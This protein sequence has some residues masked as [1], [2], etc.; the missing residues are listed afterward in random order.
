MTQET[1]VLYP[2]PGIDH[3]ISMVEL[4]KLLQKQHPYSITILLTTGLLD[5]HS[6]D[7]YIRHISASHPISFLRLP[8]IIPIAVAAPGTSFPA[9][10]FDFIKRNTPHVASTLAEISNTAIVKAM[11]IDLFNSSVEEIASSAGIP[12]Y[13]F[14]TSGIAVLALFSYFPTLHQE[15]SMS[16]KDM[17]GKEVRVPG[18][19]SLKTMHMREDPAYW[20]MLE[21]CTRLTRASG[22]MVNSFAELEPLAVRAVA[23][24]TCFPNPKKPPP[25]YYIGPLIAESQQSDEARDSKQCLSW[26]DEQPPRSVVFLCFGSLGSFSVSQLSEIAKGLERSG[27]RFLWVVKR[28]TQEEGTNL[29]HDTKG[30]FDPSSVLPNGFM[31]RTKER[32]LV[33]SSWAPQVKVLSHDSVGGFV[34]HCGWNSVLEGVVAGVPM[35]AWPLYAEQHVNKHVMVMVTEMKAAVAVERREEDGLVSGEEVEKRVR[36]VMESEEMRE[37]SL[38]LKCMALDAVGEF[39]SSTKVLANLVQTWTRVEDKI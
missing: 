5:H 25:V 15:T 11:V 35:V 26:L 6:I 37:R 28:P 16:F 33:V 34:T 27:H 3:I 8:H 21:F 36:E 39:G 20:D 17:V 12:L 29:V 18:N 30:E 24:G 38:K 1:I 10:A 31:E 22:I 4:A 32:G 7:T 23:E 2:S 14:F 9:K 19:A 13:Y